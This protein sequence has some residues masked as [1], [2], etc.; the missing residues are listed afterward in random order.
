MLKKTALVPP[1][2]TGALMRL[3]RKDH[4]TGPLALISETETQT[5]PTVKTGEH[6]RLP[7]L[8]IYVEYRRPDLNA[9]VMLYGAILA[10]IEKHRQ[11]PNVMYINPVLI[12]VLHAQYPAFLHYPYNGYY[13]YLYHGRV[14]AIPIATER[15]LPSLL[16]LVVQG[17]PRDTVVAVVNGEY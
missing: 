10:S 6:P 15:D 9:L 1:Q 4:Q 7:A 14:I 16:K 2:S 3:W 8:P 5:L 17:I 11:P 12:P 13:M